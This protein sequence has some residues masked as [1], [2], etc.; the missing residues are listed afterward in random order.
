MGASLRPAPLREA[1][2]RRNSASNGQPPSSRT[3]SSA[4]DP[5]TALRVAK[6]ACAALRPDPGSHKIRVLVAA[7]N[8]LLREALSRML[9]K[10]EQIEIVPSDSVAPLEVAAQAN[11]PVDVLLLSSRGDIEKDLLAVEQARTALPEARI[12][13]IGM[14]GNSAE[15]LRCVRAGARGYLL[16]DASAE[17]VSEGVRAIH[18][19]EA[20]CPGSLCT[21][22]FR[23]FQNEASALPCGSARQRLGLTRREQQL[24]PLIAQGLTNKEIANHFSLSEQTVKNHLYRMKHKI[25]AEDRLDIVHLYRVQGFLA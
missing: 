23:Y 22:L 5:A 20:V 11:P 4:K 19:G 6:D 16:R 3:K 12:L 15:F 1:H 17:E 14:A 25:N 18:A 21:V 8:R 13:L 9:V 7:E 2:T 10:Y 24:I